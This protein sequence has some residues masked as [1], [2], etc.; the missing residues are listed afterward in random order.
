MPASDASASL[1]LRH[2][3]PTEWYVFTS[4]TS[5][6]TA[7]LT[8]DYFPYFVQD[9]TLTVEAMTLYTESSHQ[10]LTVPPNMSSQL[11]TKTEKGLPL[12]TGGGT[13]ATKCSRSTARTR[14][15]ISP[16]PTGQNTSPVKHGSSRS[17][18]GAR[19]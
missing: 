12:S 1:S 16:T 7:T 6:F 2:D 19:D 5:D 11:K 17:R 4:G 9:T 10:P 18:G 3:F 15:H 8:I 13:L 14:T